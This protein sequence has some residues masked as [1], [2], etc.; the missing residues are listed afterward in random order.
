[1]ILWIAIVALLIWNIFLSVVLIA[2]VSSLRQLWPQ[3]RVA[4]YELKL[5]GGLVM[6]MK[7]KTKGQKEGASHG[8]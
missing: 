8:L 3:F 6:F 5:L 7:S 2:V 4:R 1:M